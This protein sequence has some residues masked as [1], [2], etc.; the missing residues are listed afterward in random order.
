MAVV[1]YYSGLD[2]TQGTYNMSVLKEIIGSPPTE[3]HYKVYGKLAD[4]TH[5]ILMRHD[6]LNINQ[7]AHA[8]VTYV[9]RC[10]T[11]P[12]C[13]PVRFSLESAYFGTA[14]TFF[15]LCAY[16]EEIRD[17]RYGNGDF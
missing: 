7:A 2:S 13:W 9:T 6:E 17:V 10:N 12:D 1:N 8:V 16:K 11:M 4:L 14:L 5:N 15:A 3:Y